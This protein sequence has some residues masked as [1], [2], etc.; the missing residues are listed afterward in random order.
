MSAK[1]GQGVHPDEKITAKNLGGSIFK[2]ALPAGVVF[3]VIA[4]IIGAASG[5]HLSRFFHSYLVALAYFLSV[6]LGALFFVV[7]QPLVKAHWSVTVRR[8]AEILTSTFPLLGVLALGIL[9]PMLLGSSGP[10]HHWVHPAP[11]DHVLHGKAAWL[12]VPFFAIRVAVYFAI[13]IFIARWF[14]NKS[15]EQDDTGDAEISDR[16]RAASGPSIIVFALTIAFAAF[17]LLMSLNPH[18]FSTIFGVYYFAGAAIAIFASLSL[19]GMFLQKKGK[20][21]R[22]IS[23][24]HYHD[25]GKLL[26]AFVFFWSYIAFS[27]FMLI[28]YANLPEETVWY[29]P[30]LFTNWSGVSILLLVA[31]TIIPFVFLLSRWTK[32][33]LSRLAFFSIW[34]MVMHYVD[35]YWIVMPEYIA[36]NQ[37]QTVFSYAVGD[38]A[39]DL[40]AFIGVGCLFVAFAARTAAKVNLIPIKDPMLGDSLKFENY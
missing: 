35:I 25:L 28:W 27:Q 32:R 11:D 40:F 14:F 30:R 13:W 36:P 31:H 18:W 37:T 19:V 34:M 26:F 23:V 9:I 16:L 38:L 33:V 4:L 6:A 7:L 8:L 22:S 5:D 10:Y 24:E 1:H 39:M 21:T 17:D 15:V 3:L 12:N 20:L 2:A 29:Q